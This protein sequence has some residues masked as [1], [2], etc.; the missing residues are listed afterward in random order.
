M[1]TS[2]LFFIVI[3]VFVGFLSIIITKEIFRVYSITSNRPVPAV[4]PAPEPCT[5][6]RCV[7]LTGIVEF[8]GNY[9]LCE[10]SEDA[11]ALEYCYTSV[12]TSCIDD[13][14]LFLNNAQPVSRISVDDA[15]LEIVQVCESLCKNQL[16]IYKVTHAFNMKQ[17]EWEVPDPYTRRKVAIME[18][19]IK[20]HD[21]LE[22]VEYEKVITYKGRKCYRSF[23][24]E[25]PYDCLVCVGDVWKNVTSPE[26]YDE[27]NADPFKPKINPLQAKILDVKD[28]WVKF[29]RIY[30][31]PQN[32]NVTT[33]SIG[34]TLC[35]NFVKMEK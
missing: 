4:C 32:K 19:N 10:G 12:K 20:L 14:I 13:C 17:C 25:S 9:F 29:K 26:L 1:K 8:L 28:G 35:P 18:E 15:E 7:G 31:D 34:E 33:F 27:L 2:Y 6:Q 21:E 16:E 23:V 22:D 11:E 5:L 24:T 3:T 30:G